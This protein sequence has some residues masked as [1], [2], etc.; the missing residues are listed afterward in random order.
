[1]TTVMPVQIGGFLLTG[2][3]DGEGIEWWWTDLAGWWE[4]GDQDQDW[5]QRTG[6]SGTIP[7]VSLYRGRPIIVRGLAEMT[8]EPYYELYQK[9]ADR[10]AGATN[11]VEA[12]PAVLTVDEF[13]PKRALVYRARAPRVRPAGTKQYPMR[14]MEFEI[15]LQAFD[16]R[17][18]GTALHVVVGGAVNNAGNVRSTPVVEV[19]GPS[20]N[21]RVTNG[22]DDGKFVQVGGTMGALN[23]AG[24]QVLTIDM[25]A[26]SAT[27]GGVDVAGLIEPGSRWWDLLPGANALA[28]AG[29]GTLTTSFRDAYN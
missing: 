7:G 10:L 6:A 13:V 11:Y 19:T 29:G 24:G 5:L 18:Y 28:L 4:G 17:K 12:A 25:D 15:P 2:D 27:V 8:V 21:P 26:M 1:M 3:I 16:W 23:L 9:A 20:A 22:T 14:V